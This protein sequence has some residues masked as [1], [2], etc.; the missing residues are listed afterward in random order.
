M[1]FDNHTARESAQGEEVRSHIASIFQTSQDSR[2]Q[3][4][5]V[6]V[7]EGVITQ[8]STSDRHRAAGLLARGEKAVA[9]LRS[10]AELH[11]GCGAGLE[12]V[13]SLTELGAAI[14]RAG[15]P[16]DA[17]VVLRDAIA[18]ADRLGAAVVADRARM[19]L[20]RAGGRA[21][22]ARDTADQLTAS[23]RRV[24]ELLLIRHPCACSCLVPWTPPRGARHPGL[25]VHEGD[26]RRPDGD[27]RHAHSRLVDLAR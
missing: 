6:Y 16:G 12:H 8:Q 23:E 11:A 1:T 7:R 9:L 26:P 18:R 25:E 22:A 10:A 24:A 14:R 13:L 2:C 3:T 20:G 5:R 17:R 21:P 27:A 15:R 4:R 19:E